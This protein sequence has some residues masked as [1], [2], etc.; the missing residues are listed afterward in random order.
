M[1]SLDLKLTRDLWRMRGQ[2]L[3]IAVVIG[4]AMATFVM[5]MGVHPFPKPPLSYVMKGQ[6]LPRP[7]IAAAG[8]CPNPRLVQLIA[9]AE[10]ASST[11]WSCCA[12]A[13]RSATKQAKW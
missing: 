2:A 12:G 1:R 5:A 9:M 13:G 7:S 6:P 10:P 11:A 3:A 8:A 4:A